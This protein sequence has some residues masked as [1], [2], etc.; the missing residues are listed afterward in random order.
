MKCVSREAWPDR[1]PSI[2]YKKMKTLK[3]IRRAFK[4]KEK[5]TG[6]LFN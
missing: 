1:K 4:T 3:L 2:P 6:L 5:L